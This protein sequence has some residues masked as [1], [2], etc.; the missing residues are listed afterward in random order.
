MFLLPWSNI[1]ETDKMTAG[2]GI[3]DVTCLSA[4][5]YKKAQQQNIYGYGKLVG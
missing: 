2:K 3:T 1:S 5:G 4:N